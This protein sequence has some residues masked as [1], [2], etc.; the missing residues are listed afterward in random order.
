MK[1]FYRKLEVKG[2]HYK[3]EGQPVDRL[4]DYFALN[5]PGSGSRVLVIV[6]H[7]D[8]DPL[9]DVRLRYSAVYFFNLRE[10]LNLL[11]PLLVIEINSLSFI[12][13]SMQ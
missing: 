1:F 5:N 3:P 7:V 6:L 4:C 8:P 9:A 10:A 13:G 2:W 11:L 12:P